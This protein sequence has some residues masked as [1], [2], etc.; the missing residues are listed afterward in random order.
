M[1][2]CVLILKF[3]SFSKICHIVKHDVKHLE[4]IVAF[5]NTELFITSSMYKLLQNCLLLIQLFITSLSIFHPFKDTNVYI[6]SIL[7]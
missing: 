2:I 7:P 5:Q 1:K 3:A 4:H 6:Q